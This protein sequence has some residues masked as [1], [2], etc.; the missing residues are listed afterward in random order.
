[1]EVEEEQQAGI[2]PTGSFSNS[3]QAKLEPKLEG[4]PAD[5]SCH[6]LRVSWVL[7]SW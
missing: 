2:E 6:R 3:A 7:H 4:T 1:M 5:P